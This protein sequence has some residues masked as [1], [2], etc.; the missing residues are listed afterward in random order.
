MA[1]TCGAQQKGQ[2]EERRTQCKVERD[3]GVR[4]ED[5]TKILTYGARGKIV[6]STSVNILLTVYGWK[7]EF[8][9]GTDGIH[10]IFCGIGRICSFQIACIHFLASVLDS[11]AGKSLIGEVNQVMFG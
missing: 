2:K 3:E 4:R 10:H 1:L 11:L 6:F 9:C 5:K 7:C 8:F